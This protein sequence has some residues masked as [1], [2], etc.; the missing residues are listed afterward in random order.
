MSGTP[1]KVRFILAWQ[2]YCVGDEI[3]PNAARRDWLI[4]NGYCQL[5]PDK[6]APVRDKAKAASQAVGALF[7]R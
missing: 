6:K 3:E 5:L 7:T 1:Q 4:G 2:N